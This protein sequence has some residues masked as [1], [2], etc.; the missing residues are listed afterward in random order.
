VNAKL[1]LKKPDIEMLDQLDRFR[2][3]IQIVLTKVDKVN[4]KD[5]LMRV[6]AKTSLETQKY[7]SVLPTIH[8]TS[9]K[10]HVGLKDLETNLALTFRDDEFVL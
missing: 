6:L 9:V 2:R 1:G 8:F 10:D 5:A 7:K 4:R 3:P